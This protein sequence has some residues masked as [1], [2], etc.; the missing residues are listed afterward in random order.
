MLPI[1][2]K[3]EEMATIQEISPET[4]ILET[5]PVIE[6][7][8]AKAKKQKTK[9]AKVSPEK[10]VPENSPESKTRPLAKVF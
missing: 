10:S 4:V 6:S 3:V 9:K 7:Q 1:V 2:E 5:V 8:P